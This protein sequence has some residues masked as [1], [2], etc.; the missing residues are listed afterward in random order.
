MK[1]IGYSERGAM[2][3]LFYGMAHDEKN[4]ES[5]MQ[6]FLG[7][8]GI[9]E[10]F[11]DFELY[12]EFSLSE[13]GDPD[14]MIIAKDKNGNSFVFFIEAKV[15]CCGSYNLSLEK[16]HHDKYLEKKEYENGH[17]SN[18]FFQLRLKHY[19]FTLSR[20]FYND[21]V[22][23]KELQEKQDGFFKIPQNGFSNYKDD[24]RNRFKLGR[25]G[26]RKIG[27]NV[28]VEKIV[29]EKI[30][31]CDNAYYIAII[32]EQNPEQEVN[33]GEYGFTTYTITWEKIFSEFNDYMGSTIDFNQNDSKSQI[34]NQPVNLKS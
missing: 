24:Q 4:G 25:N 27:K 13:F 2:N 12:S 18:L 10:N 1:I 7:L 5:A 28:V 31:K 6:K 34:M 9:T 22:N 30:Q 15:S 29:V 11:T 21:K 14:M 32:P 20:L 17:S 33:T 16:K 26:H 19:F 8:A 23:E 3:A